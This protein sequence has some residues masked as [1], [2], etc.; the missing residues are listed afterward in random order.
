MLTIAGCAL[1]AIIALTVIWQRRRDRAARRT[2]ARR[3]GW[4]MFVRGGDEFLSRLSNITLLQLGYD[5]R[6]EAAFSADG[7]L[8]LLAYQCRTGFEDRRRM[9][10]WVIAVVQVEHALGRAA[11]TTEVWLADAAKMLTLRPLRPTS[12][13]LGDAAGATN[14]RMIL[15]EDPGCWTDVYG[16]KLLGWLEK[17]P[18]RR[19]WELV[20]G[21]LIGYEPGRLGDD[22]FGD[23]PA[24]ARQFAAMLAK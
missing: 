15:V 5:R 4:R 14:G 18:S 13:G 16:R 24:R 9:H 8:F 6:V 2:W 17:E 20:P 12:R 7:P 22:S 10:R 3:H 21:Y 1:L 11:F 19:T 23:L